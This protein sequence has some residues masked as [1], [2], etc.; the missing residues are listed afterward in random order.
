MLSW[1]R[2][3]RHQ[4]SIFGL[5]KPTVE[6]LIARAAHGFQ[7]EAPAGGAAATIRKT[8]VAKHLQQGFLCFLICLKR[9]LPNQDANAI[10]LDDLVKIA[11]TRVAYHRQ[12]RGKIFGILGRGG[13]QLA[14]AGLD[15][16][17]RY[18]RSIQNTV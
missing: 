8:V 11:D 1:Q 2:L 10:G 16:D 12:A 7:I 14:K 6:T 5:E 18:I 15:E 3:R 17:H 13:A 4:T 9:E